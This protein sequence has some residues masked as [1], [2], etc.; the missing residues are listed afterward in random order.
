PHHDHGHV[1]GIDEVALPLEGAPH[2]PQA[3]LGKDSTE[4]RAVLE[5]DIEPKQIDQEGSG[6]KR[7]PIEIRAVLEDD[8]QPEQNDQDR[9]EDKR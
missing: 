2:K 3:I 1:D 5:D 4:L 8:I 6:Q 7:A 9:K